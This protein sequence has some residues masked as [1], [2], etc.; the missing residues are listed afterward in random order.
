MKDLG[1]RSISG[2]LDLEIPNPSAHR[3]HSQL[4]PLHSIS[5]L[6]VYRPGGSNPPPRGRNTGVR[7]WLPAVVPTGGGRDGAMLRRRF[8][9]ERGL[10]P[11][12][13]RSRSSS[14][15]LVRH[16]LCHVAEVYLIPSTWAS[17]PRRERPL[18]ARAARDVV[19]TSQRPW[20]CIFG[21][22][23]DWPG[24]PSNAASTE[25]IVQGNPDTPQVCPEARFWPTW[26][27]DASLAAPPPNRT[28]VEETAIS[29]MMNLHPL[30]R[31]HRA[32]GAQ[33]PNVETFKPPTV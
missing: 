9:F 23:V 26:N 14:Q 18:A 5:P 33:V 15:G 11:S 4:Q 10:R 3:G 24:N 13:S 22:F 12:I 20:G 19:P 27:E 8:N 16:R 32:T 7:R 29:G 2:V 1:I 17:S 6:M 21:G 25:A 30:Y 28:R 31:T